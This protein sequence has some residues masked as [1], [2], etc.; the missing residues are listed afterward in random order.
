M[1]L[2]DIEKMWALDSVIDSTDLGRCS[3]DIPK[4]HAKYYQIL[5]AEKRN[6]YV[7]TEKKESLEGILE[8]YFLKT[9]TTQERIEANLPDFLDKK[10]LKTEVD[11]YISRWPEIIQLNLKIAIQLDKI[12]FLKDINKMIHNRSFTIKDAISWLQYT[13]GQS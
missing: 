2:E 4:L 6:L 13:A 10:V 12:E 5:L 1:K 3:L 8:S 7:L 11:K 9:M